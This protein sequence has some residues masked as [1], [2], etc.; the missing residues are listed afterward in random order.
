MLNYNEVIH[1]VVRP[2]QD[3]AHNA[4]LLRL[5]VDCCLVRFLTVEDMHERPFHLNG[6]KMHPTRA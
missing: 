2:H 4:I 3:F 5:N 1:D 6:R